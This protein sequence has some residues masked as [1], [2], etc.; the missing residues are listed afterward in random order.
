LLFI[1]AG[2]LSSYA[3]V[4]PSATEGRSSDWSA[5]AGVSSL[6]EDYG[7]GRILGGTLWVDYSPAK[8]FPV[9]HRVNLE[10]EGQDL[11]HHSPKSVLLRLDTVA[12]GATYTLADFH[13]F[14]P[15]AK[16]VSG[17]GNVD[18]LVDR[19]RRFNQSRTVT[20]IG[21]GLEYLA[22]KQVSVRLDYEYQYYSDFWVNSGAPLDPQGF[23]LG[24]IYHFSPKRRRFE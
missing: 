18:Y 8:L 14:R 21:G 17:L 1:F 20:S 15:Y 4:A 11:S 3:Q 7:H 16:V 6:L 22:Y 12:L 5:G 13:G 19:T 24:A 10:L 9:L 23:T 2:S